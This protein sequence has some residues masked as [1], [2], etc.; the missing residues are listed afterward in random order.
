VS[1]VATAELRR[2]PHFRALPEGSLAELARLAR[3]RSLRAGEALFAEGEPAR[4]FY[5]VKSGAV[6]LYRLGRE[7]REQVLHHLGPGRSF[8]EAA[9][10]SMP[11]Y[12]AHAL[13]LETPTELVEIAGAPFRALLAR[14]GELAV[15][16][17]SSLSM[18][19]AGL[20]DRI[21][22]L[23]LTSAAARLAHHLLRRPARREGEALA[24]PLEMA[25]KE[26]AQH[27]AMTPETLSRVLRRWQDAGVVR[28]EG[29]RL[30]VLD[31][32]RLDALAEGRDDLSGRA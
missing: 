5:F 6:K 3:V 12:P 8:A 16:M 10:L 2:M 31:E 30:V 25:K 28:S 11:A 23:S 18:W 13:A 1:E 27:L 15:A 19:L 21:E 32:D 7:G 24:I 14:D 29:A 17:V 20:A 4:A 22:E 9:V 26:L